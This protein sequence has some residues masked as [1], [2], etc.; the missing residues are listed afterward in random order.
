[1]RVSPWVA[2]LKRPARCAGSRSP[3]GAR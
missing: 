2:G 1:M 3:T